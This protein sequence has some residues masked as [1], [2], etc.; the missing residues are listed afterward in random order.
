MIRQKLLVF[1][2]SVIALTAVPVIH[3]VMAQ[4]AAPTPTG[5]ADILKQL[6][7]TPDQQK[8]VDEIQAAAAVKIKAVLTP[9]QLTQLKTLAEAGKGDVD[10]FKDLNL[11]N[12]QK[13]K[14]NNIKMSLG[15]ELFPILTPEQQQKL[16]NAVMPQP[17]S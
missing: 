15:L 8:R 7:L 13:V 14:L 9:D 17:K 6:N 4:P 5:V 10:S 2:A 11:T 1:C 16:M 3:P 12:D